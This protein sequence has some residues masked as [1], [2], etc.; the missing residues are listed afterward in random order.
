MCGSVAGPHAGLPAMPHAAWPFTS[1]FISHAAR[2]FCPHADRYQTVQPLG[3]AFISFLSA[4]GFPRG[5]S[6]PVA[7]ARRGSRRSPMMS[8]QS[9]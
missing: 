2:G 1:A 9:W 4:S 3:N 8:T 5:R 7:S 6:L